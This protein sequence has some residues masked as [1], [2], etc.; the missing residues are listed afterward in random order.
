MKIGTNTALAFQTKLGGGYSLETGN[1][2]DG[3]AA[4][5][6]SKVYRQTIAASYLEELYQDHKES[7]SFL[8]QAKKLYPIPIV[9]QE[10]LLAELPKGYPPRIK[11][12]LP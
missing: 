6:P 11:R 12:S 9:A 4:P 10:E 3:E 5:P 2:A 1:N 7:L 8:A